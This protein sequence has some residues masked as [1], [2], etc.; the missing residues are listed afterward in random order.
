M[1]ATV[2]FLT[3]ANIRPIMATIWLKS[4][5][6]ENQKSQLYGSLIETFVPG[7]TVEKET[8][9]FEGEQQLTSSGPSPG[10]G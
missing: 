10:S 4:E 2:R 3:V 9:K 7:G 1:L 6:K 5:L 8:V